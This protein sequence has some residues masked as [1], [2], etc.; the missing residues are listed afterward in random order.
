MAG[1][2]GPHEGLTTKNGIE[3]DKPAQQLSFIAEGPSQLRDQTLFGYWR[4]WD[5]ELIECILRKSRETV[6]CTRFG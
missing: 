5:L 4:E 3:V 6:S 2:N 1:T